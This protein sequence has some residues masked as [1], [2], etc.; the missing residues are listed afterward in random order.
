MPNQALYGQIASR[1]N[2]SLTELTGRELS[3]VRLRSP[4]H[5]DEADWRV[6]MTTTRSA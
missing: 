6:S 3:A 5:A 2:G 1:G 4:A